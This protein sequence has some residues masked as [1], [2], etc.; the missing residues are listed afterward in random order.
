[1]HYGDVLPM[2]ECR[3]AG[4]LEEFVEGILPV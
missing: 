4:Q 2:I 1:V 3:N